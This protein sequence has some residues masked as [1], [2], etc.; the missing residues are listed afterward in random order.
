MTS[1]ISKLSAISSLHHLVSHSYFDS[2]PSCAKYRLIDLQARRS[3][4]LNLLIQS[5]VGGKPSRHDVDL[6][7]SL[8]PTLEQSENLL[9]AG[10][11]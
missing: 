2:D 5:R 4:P 8:R 11:S 3:R 10:Y 6:L 7:S 9:E 1:E